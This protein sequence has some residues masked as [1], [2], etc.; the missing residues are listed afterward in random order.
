MLKKVIQ[1]F[2]E[3]FYP[4]FKRTFSFEVYAYL[5]V[6][7][8]NT[9]FNILIFAGLYQFVLPLRGFSIGDFV[10]PASTTSL[11]VAFIV[12]LPTGFWL[13][14]H[15]AF[16]QDESKSTKTLWQ[17]GK[18]FLVVLQGL[19]TDYLL[20]MV[21]ITWGGIHPIVA[22]VISTVVVLT[23][24]FLLQKNFTFRVRAAN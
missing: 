7:G 9:A 23:F 20:L 18:Y 5:A 12:T 16:R 3:L 22:K 21:L 13:A 4:L 14:K 1:H 24:N 6:G 19:A 15:F 17:L 11:M 10:I 2:L 8:L